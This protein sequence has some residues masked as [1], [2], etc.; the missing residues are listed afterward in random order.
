MEDEEGAAAASA[1]A[2]AAADEIAIAASLNLPFAERVADKNWKIRKAAFDEAK[3]ACEKG[4]DSEDEILS[5][6]GTRLAQSDRLY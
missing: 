5:E 6:Y 3:A 2:A 4:L 1:A